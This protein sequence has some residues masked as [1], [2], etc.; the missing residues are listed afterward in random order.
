M[1]RHFFK[2][3]IDFVCSLILIILLSFPFLIIAILIKLTS[4][5][6]VFFKQIRIGKN[7]STFKILKFRT[8]VVGAEKMKEG[9]SIISNDT[10]VTKLGK[11]LRK[12]SLD[13]LPQVF[14][15]LAGQMAF[16]GPR[17]P[18]FFFFP[19][20]ENLNDEC[21]KRFLVKPGITGYSQV[22]G[23][24]SFSWYQKI[25]YDNIYIDKLKKLGILIDIWIAFKTIGRIFSRKNIEE[26][27]QVKNENEQFLKEFGGKNNG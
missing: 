7:G 1:Y 11:F 19:K 27:E 9:V 26:T 6:P 8:M 14:N 12:T 24:N 22:I 3:V 23:R 4:K 17:A 13:E 21:K 10:R 25:K 20:Y 18:A 15:V 2:R 16:I 5:G